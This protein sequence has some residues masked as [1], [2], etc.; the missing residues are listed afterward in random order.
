MEDLKREGM[1]GGIGISVNRWEPENGIETLRTGI[2]DAVQ[3]IY[4]VFDQAPED[5]LFPVCQELDVAVIARVPFDEGS[6]TG[7]LTRETRFPRTDF[8]H[9]YFGPENLGP[10]M[11]RVDALTPLV[12][13]GSSLPDLAMRFIL[14]NR[15]V[16]T[17][18]PGMRRPKHVRANIA[19]SDAA[20]LDP[21]LLHELR[22]HRWDRRP[23]N[24]SA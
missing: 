18:I 9:V 3:V 1:I 13:H 11:D 14:A 22:A 12:P 7:T 4:N 20:P 2:V 17:V 6:L 10:T 21:E 19:T 16:S 8:R 5:E 23:A 24:W 15:D